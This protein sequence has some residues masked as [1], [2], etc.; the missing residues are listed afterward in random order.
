MEEDNGKS[1]VLAM[2]RRY[3]LPTAMGRM[4]PLGFFSASN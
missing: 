3:V 1:A 4:S 2:R